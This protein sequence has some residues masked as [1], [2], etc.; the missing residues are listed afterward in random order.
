MK[1]AIRGEGSTDIGV[2]NPVDFLQKGPMLILLEKLDCYRTLLERLGFSEGLNIEDFMEWEYIHKDDIKT[3]SSSRRKQV[4]RGKKE[5]DFTLKG[6]YKNSEAFACIAKEKDADMAIFTDKTNPKYPK[7][8]CD[9]SGKTRYQ[10]AQECD[11]NKIDMPSF[12]RFREDFSNAV[13]CY[14]KYQI[15]N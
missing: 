11:P 6:F 4:L 9:A 3:S 8:V 2:L 5:V 15:C 7:K 13:N 14:I 10:I 1:I 12:N